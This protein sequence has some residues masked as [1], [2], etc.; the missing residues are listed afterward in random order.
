MK[1]PIKKE[2]F[3]FNM[4]AVPIRNAQ[5]A[6]FLGSLMTVPKSVFRDPD[7]IVTR[8]EIGGK[9]EVLVYTPVGI[10]AD[11]PCLVYYHGGGF[12]FGAAGYHYDLARR[13]SLEVGCKVVF[14]NYRLAYKHKFPIPLGDCYTAYKWT[15]SNAHRLGV[16]PNRIA[17]GGDSAGGALAA[18]V[19][20][21][22]RDRGDRLPLF[23][24]L[25]YPGTDRHMDSVSNRIFTDTPMWNSSLSKIMWDG[26]LDGY[27]G[28]Y[29]YYASPLEADDHSGLPD[30]YVET[31]EYDCLRD[32][33]IEYA[34]RL[35]EGGAAVALCETRGTMHG[36]DIVKNAPTTQTAVSNRIKYMKRKFSAL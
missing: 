26:Y 12:F 2:F 31:A 22:A 28:K 9:F 6:G 15:I 13:Y 3:P 23:Q 14:V 33:G 35:S 4:F 25:V 32:E 20:M 11:A 19:A 17:V 16:D 34:M 18:G 7:V 29:V 5:M 21:L 27:S 24:L 30:A 10:G 1:Y 36:F 8:A